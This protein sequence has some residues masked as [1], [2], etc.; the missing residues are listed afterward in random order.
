MQAGTLFAH[1]LPIYGHVVPNTAAQCRCS[2]E[3]PWG[4]SAPSSVP[5]ATPNPQTG[6]LSL[7]DKQ[8]TAPFIFLPVKFGDLAVS[9]LADSRAMHSFLAASLLPKL[10]DLP[11]FVSIVPC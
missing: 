10:R 7:I 11:S 9:T 8:N 1:D 2:F 3:S 6:S 5:N 4:S